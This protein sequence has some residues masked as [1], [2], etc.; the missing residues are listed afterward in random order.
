MPRKRSK[1]QPWFRAVAR[2]WLSDDTLPAEA[3]DVLP[4]TVLQLPH[5]GQHQHILL[6]DMGA[7]VEVDAPDATTEEAPEAVEAAPVED[8]PEAAQ[9]VNDG[10][11]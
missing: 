1:Q 6:L 4:G 5:L 10:G 7:I 2:L 11:W 9:E 3:R 8:A